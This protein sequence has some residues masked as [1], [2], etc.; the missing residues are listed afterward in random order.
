LLRSDADQSLIASTA[1]NRK[2]QSAK[3]NKQASFEFNKNVPIDATK[4]SM[5]ASANLPEHCSANTKQGKFVVEPRIIQVIK[6]PRTFVNHSYRDF[7]SVP[8]EDG[9]IFPTEIPEMTFPQ[10]VY[11]MLSQPEYSR[12]ISWQPHGRSFRVHLPKQFET[13]VCAKYLGHTRYS[14]FLRQLSNHSF[15]HITQGQ[16]RNCYYHEVCITMQVIFCLHFSKY[17][18]RPFYS[19][20]FKFVQF[21]L[22]G[23]PHLCKFM[24]KPKDA[25]RLIPD[26]VNEPDFYAISAQDPLSGGSGPSGEDDAGQK[27]DKTN[28]GVGSTRLHSIMT[29]G[30]AVAPPS[31]RARLSPHETPMQAGIEQLSSQV[32]SPSS[33]ASH[34][35]VT[36][37][38][39]A[40]LLAATQHLLRGSGA[41]QT[42]ALV[43][44]PSSVWSE[45][46][47][48]Q[49]ASH[50]APQMQTVVD[51]TSLLMYAIR[52]GLNTLFPAANQ[53]RVVPPL[54]SA[55]PA[56]T[57]VTNPALA[58]LAMMLLQQATAKPTA[59]Q[60]APAP[61]SP[62]N[63]MTNE[64]LS[65]LSNLLNLT[66]PRYSTK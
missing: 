17:L 23:R 24:P 22:R 39:S 34:R 14:S 36:S 3:G 59:T 16:D 46:A 61:A 19:F 51:D 26:P 48:Q 41:P 44:F 50:P 33:Y 37:L 15:K 20:N 56:P 21:M 60:V 27:A 25:R 53:Q 63:S 8:A 5:S 1:L 4:V 66:N 54:P 32:A 35:S 7:S 58:S 57:V 47:Q 55:I 43:P 12:F 9:D 18:T 28:S 38:G 49:T 13:K 62:S 52:A 42:A 6:K 45:V 10:K 30:Q 2:S 11:H 29:T 64:Q 40:S 31:K 65:A